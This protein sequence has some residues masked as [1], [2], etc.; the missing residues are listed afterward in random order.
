MNDSSV[1]VR[2]LTGQPEDVALS[3]VVLASD[4]IFATPFLDALAD[5]CSRML[6]LTPNARPAMATEL[7]RAVDVP[8]LRQMISNNAI[9]AA[10]MAST[11]VYLLDKICSLQAPVNTEHT[12]RWK[13]ELLL[14]LDTA[15][16]M[17]EF[18]ACV[19]AFFEF[20]SGCIDE[21][22][23]DMTN[24]Y[25]RTLAPALS[26]AGPTYLR[27]FFCINARMGLVS[28]DRTAAWLQVA[29]SP[30]KVAELQAVGIVATY[31]ALLGLV[32]E[33]DQATQSYFTALAF[34][35]L[36]QSSFR[37][38]SVQNASQLPETVIRDATALSL[39]R[40]EMDT[41]ALLSTVLIV[42]K[43]TLARLRLQLRPEEEAEIQSRL[44]AVVRSATVVL[45]DICAEGVRFVREC[46]ARQGVAAGKEWEDGMRKA[47]SD[48]VA[49]DNVVRNLF[50][51]R[52]IKLILSALV[53]KPFQDLLP[54]YSLSSPQQVKMLS[55]II[56][57]TKRVY[58]LNVRTFGA[59][60][61]LIY[62][63]CV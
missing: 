33:S 51:K 25:V 5:L 15:Q 6:A 46:V 35:L 9:G 59:F 19:P 31:D 13:Q 37:L 34:T 29:S 52:I 8:L 14:W 56:A 4:G 41:L 3:R 23:A 44:V 24:F 17:S 62:K 16:S 49:E 58:V 36:L 11:F 20:C 57:S 26:K 1:T 48:T 21:I 63:Y 2:F 55:S 32:R 43:Q 10:D 53:D 60:Y 18:V 45:S 61:D 42:V 22:R 38:D 12:L 40:D 39:I 30:D 54:I 28:L 27:T 47:I 7:D 50:S